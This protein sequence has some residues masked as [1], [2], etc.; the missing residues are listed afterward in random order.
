MNRVLL[1]AA[2]LALIARVTVFADGDTVEAFISFAAFWVFAA[3]WL[4]ATI[5]SAATA[6]GRA[7]PRRKAIAEG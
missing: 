6:G 3:G 4:V 1:A 7:G 2:S 5:A